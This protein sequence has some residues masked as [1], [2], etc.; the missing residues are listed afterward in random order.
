MVP[1]S[2]S[3]TVRARTLRLFGTRGLGERP[4]LFTDGPPRDWRRPR[5]RPR[6]TWT[7]TIEDD[8][9]HHELGLH[10]AWWRAQDIGSPG[11][12]SWEPLRSKEFAPRDDDDDEAPTPPVDGP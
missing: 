5:G 12:M 2:V 4:R 8:L 1:P 7:R 11:D 10:S 6:L 9:H 3:D